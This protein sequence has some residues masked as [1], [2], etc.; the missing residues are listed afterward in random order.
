MK[1]YHIFNSRYDVELDCYTQY[2][3]KITKLQKTIIG[4]VIKLR[5]KRTYEPVS[6]WLPYILR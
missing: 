4:F 5:D 3:N 1:K 6:Y 2:K